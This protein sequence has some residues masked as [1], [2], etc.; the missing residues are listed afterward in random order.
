MA[1]PSI[2]YSRCMFALETD[3]ARRVLLIYTAATAVQIA[4]GIHVCCRYLSFCLVH[5]LPMGGSRICQIAKARG[6]ADYGERASAYKALSTL[7]QKSAT[8]AENGELRRLSHFSA[9]V[10]TGVWERK[11]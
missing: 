4:A 6:G 2:M 7:W 3:A 9:T 11:S 8:V 5:R 1:P 10:W